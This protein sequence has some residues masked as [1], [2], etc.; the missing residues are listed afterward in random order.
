MSVI[1]NKVFSIKRLHKKIEEL[2]KDQIV[3]FA[4]FLK[5]GGCSKQICYHLK[6]SE[7][8]TYEGKSKWRKL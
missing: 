5:V 4:Y 1:L 8:M 6:I 7:S 3:E 2:E